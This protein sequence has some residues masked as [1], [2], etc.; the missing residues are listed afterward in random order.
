MTDINV[1]IIHKAI[2]NG[3]NVQELIDGMVA[4]KHNKIKSI[5]FKFGGNEMP[6]VLIEYY[7][8]NLADIYFDGQGNS[9]LL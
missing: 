3:E 8:E 4:N 7:R 2:R 1:E 9:Y 5:D 6:D